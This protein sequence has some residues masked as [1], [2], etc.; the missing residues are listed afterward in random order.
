MNQL[1]FRNSIGQTNTVSSRIFQIK[2]NLKIY[3]DRNREIQVKYT[4]NGEQTEFSGKK[5]WQDKTLP[6]IIFYFYK[7]G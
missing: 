3:D 6:V 7:S 1:I 2:K 5:M 4:Y